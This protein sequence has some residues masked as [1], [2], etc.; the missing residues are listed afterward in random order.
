MLAPHL[1]PDWD[2]VRVEHVPFGRSRLDVSLRRSGSRIVAQLTRTDA[3]SGP[4]IDVTFSP[5]LPLGATSSLP[6]EHTPG[7]VHATTR[8]TLRDRLT[9]EVAYSG[10]WSIVPPSM[11]AEIGERSHAP[12]VLSERLSGRQYVATLEG[13]A[14]RT[15]QFRVRETGKPWRAVDVTFPTSGAN[16][17]GYSTRT[18]TLSGR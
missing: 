3:P 8:G 11:P 6:L 7:D 14:G 4:P 18:L 9:L 12:R 5:A 13:L 2:S 10:G 15:Y 17:D 16:P 1:P